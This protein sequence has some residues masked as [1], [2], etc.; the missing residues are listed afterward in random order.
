MAFEVVILDEAQR[1]YRQ[2]VEYLARIL[3]SPQAAQSFMDSFE[4]IITLIAETPE[5]FALSRMEELA[6]KGYR[7]ALVKNYGMLYTIREDKVIIAH[8]FHQTQDYARLV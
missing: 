2:I 4:D 5:L 1:E 8:I 7:T 3:C 6:A